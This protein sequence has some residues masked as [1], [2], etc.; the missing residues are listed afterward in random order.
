MLVLKSW[1]L[2]MRFTD[3]LYFLTNSNTTE[4]IVNLEFYL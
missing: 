3:C 4:D 1:L 2:P